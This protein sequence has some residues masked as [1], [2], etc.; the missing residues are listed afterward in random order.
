MRV[1]LFLFAEYRGYSFLED[2][3]LVHYFLRLDR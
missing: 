1:L 3:L 2:R